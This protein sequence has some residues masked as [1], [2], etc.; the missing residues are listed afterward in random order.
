[1]LFLHFN[2]HM[3]TQCQ[4][5]KS[6]CTFLS[7]ACPFVFGN[8]GL[9]MYGDLGSSIFCLCEYLDRW[10]DIS[11]QQA[12]QHIHIHTVLHFLA[13]KLEH[14]ELTDNCICIFV[15]LLFA[16]AWIYMTLGLLFD[17]AYYRCYKVPVKASFQKAFWIQDRKVLVAVL[18]SSLM[19]AGTKI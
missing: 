10:M 5:N 13:W 16:T 2:C 1:M 12:L 4:T 3:E 19:S 11:R 14:Y 17:M 18:F 7:V 15:V 8:D 9:Y 6:P